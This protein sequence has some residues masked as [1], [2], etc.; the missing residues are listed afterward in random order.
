MH[1]NKSVCHKPFRVSAVE[2]WIHDFGAAG[3]LAGKGRCGTPSRSRAFPSSRGL[4]QAIF[5]CSALHNLIYSEDFEIIE[6]KKKPVESIISVGKQI[7]TLS[8]NV[9]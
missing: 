4:L 5:L 8:V 2:E 1:S 7:M 9:I 3:S 6:L